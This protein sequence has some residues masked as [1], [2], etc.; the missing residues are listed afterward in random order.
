MQAE[1]GQ[2]RPFAA[3]LGEHRK[4]MTM[5]E[6]SKALATVSAAVIEHGKAGSV[7]LKL[8]VKPLAGTADGTVVLSDEI[9]AKI[10]AGERGSSIFFSDDGGNLTRTNP[11]QPELPG[12]RALEG[13]REEE[14]A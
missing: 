9:V 6:L 2:V 11:Y 1:P 3:V 4:G 8:T 10:P 7:T 13:G 5:L 14:T 12:M